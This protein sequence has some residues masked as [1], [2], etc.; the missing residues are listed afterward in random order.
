[1]ILRR[2]ATSIRKQDWFAVVI[3]TL[4]VVMGVYLGIQLGN[5]NAARGNQTAY[6]E[7]LERFETE[8]GRNMAELE[9]VVDD[10]SRSLPR[11]EAAIEA[12]QA[13]TDSEAAV[14]AVNDGLQASRVTASIHLRMVALEDLTSDPVLLSQQ[15]SEMRQHLADLAFFLN[16]FRVETG[17]AETR[18]LEMPAAFERSVD[19]GPPSPLGDVVYAGRTYTFE[20]GKRFPLMLS[21][22]VSEA[23]EEGELIKVL[24]NW[25][26]WQNNVAPFSL[27]AR[28]ELD[29]IRG[30]VEEIR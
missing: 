28:D 6:Q 12:L 30:L 8:I 1:M 20:T 9:R 3:E 10:L 17:W 29:D 27:A 26:G 25:H 13:C 16:L 21:V 2:L 15:S 18:P 11:V 14:E 4:I 5:W 24:Y 23:C 7:A 19:I 22:P